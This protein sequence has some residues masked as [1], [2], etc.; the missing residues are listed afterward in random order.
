MNGSLLSESAKRSSPLMLNQ[1]DQFKKGV[2][3]YALQISA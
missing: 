3:S 2:I 1:H